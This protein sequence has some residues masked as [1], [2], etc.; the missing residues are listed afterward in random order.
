MPCGQSILNECSSMCSQ[1]TLETLKTRRRGREW[2]NT[3]CCS[4]SRGHAHTLRHIMYRR[5]VWMDP[6][7]VWSSLFTVGPCSHF[8]IWPAE[9]RDPKQ[10]WCRKSCWFGLNWKTEFQFDSSSFYSYGAESKS[11][12]WGLFCSLFF[13]PLLHVIKGFVRLTMAFQPQ[14]DM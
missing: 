14:E 11:L 4:L 5:T 3:Q 7:C 13:F 10:R 9:N 6:H 2:E 1:A 8:Y 12:L